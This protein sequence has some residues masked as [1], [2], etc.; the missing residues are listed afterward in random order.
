[1][2]SDLR[3][4]WIAP[5]SLFVLIAVGFGASES[6]LSDSNGFLAQVSRDSVTGLPRSLANRELAFIRS[7][8][9]NQEHIYIARPNGS[10]LRKLDDGKGCKQRPVWAPDGRRIAYRF[11]PRCDYT[12]DQV[13]VIDVR[14]SRR[15]NISRRTGIFGNSPSWSSNGRRIAFAGIPIV[16]GKPA[17]VPLGLYIAKSDGATARRVTP[18]SLGEV[19]YPFWSP[20]GKWIA[21]QISN[22]ST[23]SGF[24]LYRIEPDGS[25]LERL[26]KSGASGVYNEWPM[27]SPDSKR[28]AYGVEGHQSALWAMSADGSAKHKIRSGIGVPASWAPGAWLV[29]NCHLP[30]G[31]PG[32]C[33]LSP[34]GSRLIRLLRGIDGGF[35]AWRP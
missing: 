20:N 8:G 13:V 18:Q 5:A 32:V 7:A 15:L 21:F 29:A 12:L 11:E 25:N 24:D 26:T 28:I 4:F 9:R 2:A 33:A 17:R 35:P 22:R 23:A 27:W 14:T 31:R 10:K 1:M 34:S 30:G 3:R 6:R 16:G 19:Q